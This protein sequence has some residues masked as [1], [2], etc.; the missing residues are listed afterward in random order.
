MPDRR[1]SSLAA[2]LLL[3]CA[4]IVIGVA[5]LTSPAAGWLTAGVLLAAWSWLVFGDVT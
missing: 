5:E 2:L 1:L 3:A 4:L